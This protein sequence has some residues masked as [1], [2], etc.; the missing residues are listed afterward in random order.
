MQGVKQCREDTVLLVNGIPLVVAEYKSY[1]ASGK[2]W[3][4]AVHQLHRYQRQ[5]PAVLTS[6]VFCV[7]ADEDE[8][9]YGTVLFHDASKDDIERH[10]DSWGRWLGL[11]PE[12]HGFWNEPEAANLQDPLEA[13]VRGLLRLKP[14]HLLDFLRLHRPRS[15]TDVGAAVDQ[16]G[17]PRARTA[18]VHLDDDA[19]MACHV[20]LGPLLA[21]K[22]HRI[23]SVHRD[24][25]GAP[26]ATTESE[27][28][29]GEQRKNGERGVRSGKHPG[30]F[31]MRGES[32]TGLERRGCAR[33]HCPG[34]L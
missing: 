8:F 33:S 14:A 1:V 4:E 15:L 23:R 2:D 3:R 10:L 26:A 21:E 24:D 25:L 11:Y 31:P 27:Q 19:F 6:N 16:S 22:H 5:A 32:A 20:L 12:R 34:L 17:D 30:S 7:A 28:G 29:Q 13:S 9:R 18:S